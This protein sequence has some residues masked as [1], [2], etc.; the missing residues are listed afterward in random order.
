MGHTNMAHYSSFKPLSDEEFSS[1]YGEQALLRGTFNTE[2]AARYKCCMASC[3]TWPLAP[4]SWPL[5]ACCFPALQKSVESQRVTLGEHSLFYS[6]D[7]FCCCGPC[8][9]KCNTVEQQVP[10]DKLQ[11]LKLQQSWCARLFD[12]WNMSM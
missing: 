3:A 12:V 7:T 2:S 4:L 9:I 11:D 5:L 6:T 10:L 1:M 8:S